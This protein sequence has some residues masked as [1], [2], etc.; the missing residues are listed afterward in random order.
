MLKHIT[1]TVIICS[2]FFNNSYTTIKIEALNKQNEYITLTI[3]RVYEK[4][5]SYD[6]DNYED[7]L[8]NKHNYKQ[9]IIGRGHELLPDILNKYKLR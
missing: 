2:V 8:A 9:I 7:Y 6:M 3:D 4:S 1:L 5:S